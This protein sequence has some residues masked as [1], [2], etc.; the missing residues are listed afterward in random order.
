MRQRARLAREAVAADEGVITEIAEAAL[1]RRQTLYAKP[2]KMPAA[3]R[4]P[5]RPP[6]VE[7]EI[8]PHPSTHT[9]EQAIEFFARRHGAYGYRRVWAKLRRAGFVCNRKKVQRLLKAWGFTRPRQRPHPKAQGR[10]FDIT[11][12]NELWATDLT[13]VWCGEDGWGYFTAVMD[14]FDRAI[15]GW[16][17][18]RRCRAAD[19]SPALQQAWSAAWPYGR[20][21]DERRVV[22]RHDN[23]TQFTSY[24]YRDVA[25]ALSVTLSRTAYRH[26]DGNAFVERLYRSLKEE[27][28]WPVEFA[29]FAEALA[30][31]EAWVTDY[32]HERPHQSLGYRTPLE[33]RRAT[34][35]DAN[36]TQTAA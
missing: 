35:Q 3:A 11:T 36:P 27:A 21:D 22:L 19:V 8:A 7:L 6:G 30:A 2:K 14:C 10:P 5:E 13:A 26:P 4:P 15:L 1:V 12:S 17:F 9:T 20:G 33:V 28:V 18:T 16:T 23:G 32:N 24:H 25:D 29:D 31:I 34:L